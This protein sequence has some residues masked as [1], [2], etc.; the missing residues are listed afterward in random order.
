LVDELFERFLTELPTYLQAIEAHE[1]ERNWP[2]L[3][4]AAHRLHGAT[5]ICGVPALNH[6]VASL[7][8]AANDAQDDSIPTLMQALRH[9]ISELLG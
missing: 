7:E 1:A 2:A 8:Q 9:E 4:A 3:A 6:V 5:A